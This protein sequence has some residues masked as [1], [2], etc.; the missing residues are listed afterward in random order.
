MFIDVV[1]L[2]MVILALVKGFGKGFIMA[3]FNTLSLIIGLAA[4]VK[5]S[6]MVAPVI[7]EKLDTGVQFAPIIAF[8]AIFAGVLLLI[9]MAGKAIE[10]T[11]E[12]ASIGFINRASGAL[13][14]LLV[15]LSIISILFYYVEKTGLLRKEVQEASLTWNL[16][17]PWGPAVLD[18]IGLLIPFFKNMFDTLNDFFE[19]VA[20][21]N[22]ANG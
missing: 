14:Y 18:G 2:I 1:V 11:F 13:L 10:K 12:T 6:A 21:G 19:Q 4:A 9:R 17:A 5:F 20:Q 7:G 16:I 8:L 3:L 22:T 15:Y